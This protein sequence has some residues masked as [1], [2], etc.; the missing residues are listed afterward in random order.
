VLALA[1]LKA[2]AV[3]D[4]AENRPSCSV[5]DKGFKEAGTLPISGLPNG[6]YLITASEC[7]GLCDSI[8]H[9]WY[10]NYWTWNRTDGSCWLVN[11]TGLQIESLPGFVSGPV[12]CTSGSSGFVHSTIAH[13]KTLAQQT[14]GGVPA[15]VWWLIASAIAIAVIAGLVFC[16]FYQ[17]GKA[18]KSK[19][20]VKTDEVE[21]EAPLVGQAVELP[22]TTSYQYVAAPQYVSTAQAPT[23]QYVTTTQASNVSVAPPVVTAVVKAEDYAPTYAAPVSTVQYAQAAPVATSVQYMQAAPVITSGYVSGGYTTIATPLE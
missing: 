10:C 17:G 22:V 8:G 15:W 23:T 13:I 6:A 19:R 16:G 14:H 20:Q 1:V 11:A 5:F 18:K 12:N 7:Q 3:I 2:S 21:V 9:K 4:D